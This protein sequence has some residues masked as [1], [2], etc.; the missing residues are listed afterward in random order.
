M[1][2]LRKVEFAPCKSL[3]GVAHSSHSLA[4]DQKIVGFV[5]D[6][7]IRSGDVSAVLELELH[8]VDA[9]HVESGSGVPHASQRGESEQVGVAG[10]SVGPLERGLHLPEEETR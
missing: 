1:P 8:V 3:V 7:D 5:E 6:D 2:K 9:A 10:G 4:N